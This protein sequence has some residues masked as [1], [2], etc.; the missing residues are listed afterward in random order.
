MPPC[1]VYRRG[2]ITESYGGFMSFRERTGVGY[3]TRPSTRVSRTYNIH[4]Y[5][6]MPTHVCVSACVNVCPTRRPRRRSKRCTN[7]ARYGYAEIKKEKKKDQKG[8][9]ATVR[10]KKGEKNEK[11]STLEKVERKM[12]ERI[13]EFKF[14][15]LSLAYGPMRRNHRSPLVSHRMQFSVSTSFNF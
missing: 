12:E 11:G 14:R 7:F 6:C 13:S 8:K 10:K 9:E 1:R 5:I 2:W 3:I 15:I 4:V